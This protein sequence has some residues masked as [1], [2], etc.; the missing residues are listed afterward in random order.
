MNR[1]PTMREYR[2]A[3]RRIW[4]H[5]PLLC[6]GVV[7]GLIAGVVAIIE[8][9]TTPW[10]WGCDG[11]S[12]PTNGLGRDVPDARA[13]SASGIVIRQVMSEAP[14]SVVGSMSDPP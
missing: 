11:C 5:D 14:A 8:I 7:L 9:A 2:A 12:C 3:L 10:R 1:E 6:V 13:T 4:N